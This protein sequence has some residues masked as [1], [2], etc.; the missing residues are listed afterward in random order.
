M[1]LFSSNSL[2]AK[3]RLISTLKRTVRSL[4]I[5]ELAPC[6]LR[7]CAS[8][9]DLDLYAYARLSRKATYTRQ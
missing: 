5:E 7:L 6:A 8:H 1:K 3:D 9:F 4:L 2:S